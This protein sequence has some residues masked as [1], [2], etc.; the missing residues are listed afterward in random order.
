MEPRVRDLFTRLLMSGQYVRLIQPTPFVAAEARDL[1]WKHAILL[2]GAG[3][4]HVASALETRAREF[5][6][7]R[8][9]YAASVMS[10]DA[11]CLTRSLSRHGRP[12]VRYRTREA[13]AASHWRPSKK[14]PGRI[15]SGSKSS[16][17]R[18]LTLYLS[19]SERGT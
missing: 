4:I 16:R 9:Q 5:L 6:L 13:K 3:Y 1:R 19:G 12:A 17:Q 7:S 2:S 18:A 14:R 8:S 11:C 10:K 15:V